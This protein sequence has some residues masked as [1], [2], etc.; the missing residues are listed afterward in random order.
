MNTFFVKYLFI[1][2]LFAL[3]IGYGQEVITKNVSELA[4]LPDDEFY[5]VLQDS[6]GNYWFC[7][8]SGLYRFDGINFTHYTN[9][10]QRSQSLFNLKED[11]FGR[12]WCNSLNVIGSL[13][14]LC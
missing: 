1:L 14:E 13:A 12:I 5:D 6:K 9:P 3:T 7:A 2:F 8:D 10:E 4:S 11:D